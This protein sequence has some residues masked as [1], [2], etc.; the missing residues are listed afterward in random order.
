MGRIFIEHL[1][2]RVYSCKSCKKHLAKLDDVMSKQFYSKSGKAYLFKSAVNVICGPLEE[3]EM[4]TG[5]HAV[6]DVYCCSCLHLLGWK[7]VM[8]HDRTQ[9]YKEGKYVLERNK[10]SDLQR[11]VHSSSPEPLTE[12][13][14]DDP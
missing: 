12:S 4:R 13:E 1:E 8:A 6:C 2:G 7:Y 11:P 3:R 10:I 9:K 14:P 5:L